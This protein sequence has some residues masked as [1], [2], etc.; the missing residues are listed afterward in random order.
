MLDG[1]QMGMKKPFLYQLVPVV[2][3]LMKVPY[4]ELGGT[5]ERVQSV[6]SAEEERFMANIDGG[7]RRLDGVFKAMEDEKRAT[8]AG[9][10]AFEMY[11]TY[12]FPPELFETLAGE[13]NYGFDWEGF[14]K[15][16]ERLNVEVHLG[17]KADAALARNGG[18][19][20]IIAATGS[21]P[22]LFP[23][24]GRRS[25]GSGEETARRFGQ[26]AVLRGKGRASRRF[27]RNYFGRRRV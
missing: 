22:K 14:G 11:Q 12:G 19:D 15:E 1:V 26:D 2:A 4:P 17:E 8:V 20:A 18:F 10:D 24:G 7:L 9:A 25:G 6:I 3:E 5:V 13:R 16:M 21:R 27:R 23:L